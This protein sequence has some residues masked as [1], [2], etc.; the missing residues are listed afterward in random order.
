VEGAGDPSEL[1]IDDVEIVSDARCGT[2]TDILDPGFD[3]GPTRAVGVTHLMPFQ[4][5]TLRSEPSLS[6]TGDGG[7]LEISYF[8]EQAVMDY[9]TWFSC[10]RAT[11]KRDRLSSTGRRFRRET[12]NR[13]ELCLAARPSIRG[14][15]F[16]RTEIGKNRRSVAG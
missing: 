15:C 13:F 4:V 1:L 8:N 12:S 5:A 10:P 2:S 7:V 6:R 14:N 11:A 16:P 9:E 3:A